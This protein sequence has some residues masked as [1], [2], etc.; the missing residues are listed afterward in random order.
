[1]NIQRKWVTPITAGAFL[2][3]AATG[4]L[5]F[6]HLESGANKLFHEWLGLVMIT[7]ATLHVTANFTGLKS[8]LASQRG[9]LLI[10]IF[11]V[12][13]LVSFAPIGDKGE[14]PF[15]R[16]IRALSQ[17]SLTT[18]AQVAQ[19]TPEHLREKLVKAGLQP[20]SNQ[21]SV[22]DL[23]GPDMKKQ[24]QILSMVFAVVK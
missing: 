15:M 1:M 21:Q 17:A 20:T 23:V 18:L 7:G 11:A 9:K 14:P 13:L 12:A 16:P 2:L 6:F 8:H 10:G 5:M 24:A 3:S 22:S 19:V 4:A